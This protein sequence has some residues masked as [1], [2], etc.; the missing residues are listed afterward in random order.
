MYESYEIAEFAAIICRINFKK[1]THE[2]PV[3]RILPWQSVLWKRLLTKK[4]KIIIESKNLHLNCTKVIDDLTNLQMKQLSVFSVSTGS[5]I[6]NIS[7]L[8]CEKAQGKS[9]EDSNNEIIC[10]KILFEAFGSSTEINLKMLPVYFRTKF[11]LVCLIQ[12]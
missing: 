10:L 8:K 6:R 11:H 1:K 9:I 3:V 7:E 2:F 4:Y 12:S 5:Q